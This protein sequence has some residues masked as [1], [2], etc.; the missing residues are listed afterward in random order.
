MCFVFVLG[1]ACGA[2]AMLAACVLDGDVDGDRRER[3]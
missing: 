1:V 2:L 3:R